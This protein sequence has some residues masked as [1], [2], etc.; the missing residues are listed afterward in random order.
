M[1]KYLFGIDLGTTYS[2]IAYVDETG[3]ATVVKNQEG[4]NTTPSVVNFASPDQVVVGEVA[5]ENAVIDPANTVQLVKTLMGKTNFAINYNG[6]DR[7]PEEVSSYILKKLTGDAAIQLDTEVK[8]VVITCPAYFGTAERNATKMAGEIAGLNVLGIINEPTAAALY[9]GA[10]KATEPKT[11]MVFDL[12]GGTFDVTI[13]SVSSNEIKVICSDGNHDLGGKLWDEAIMTY[14]ADQFSAQTGVSTDEMDEYAQQDLRLKAEK[15]KQQLSSRDKVPVMLDIAGQR[16]RI[17]ITRE[18]FDEI[19]STLL[20]QAIDKTNAALE[21]A[22]QKGYTV[23]EILLVGG[24]TRMPQVPEAIKKAYNMEPKVLEPD[25]AVAKGA[26]IYAVAKYIENKNIVE[27]ALA[28]GTVETNAEGEKVVH[29]KD[30]EEVKVKDTTGDTASRFQ[31]GGTSGAVPKLDEIIVPATTKSYAIK[32]MIDGK[33]VCYNMI[34]KNEEMPKGVVEH[35]ESFGT[36]VDNQQNVELVIYENDYMDDTFPVDDNL[37][38]GKATLEIAN[39][40]PKNSPIQVTFSLS[41]EGTLHV[42]GLDV[43]NNK[44]IEAD[45]KATGIMTEEEKKRIQEQTQGIQVQ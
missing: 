42:T 19:T 9:Y 1:A 26:A 21:V 32:V 22:K 43:T 3:R 12:G 41:K 28:N 2:C 36:M 39:P 11:I 4:S 7:T 24:S 23:G 17:E 27:E 33:Q 5:K 37:I 13:M 44:K 38:L 31:L 20:A 15:A 14:L 35:S 6:K 45:L 25:E 34:K 30:G 18:K 8:D 16:A 40:L 10:T 29:T